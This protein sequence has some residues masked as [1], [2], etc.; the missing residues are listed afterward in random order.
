MI[1]ALAVLVIVVG[2]ILALAWGTDEVLVDTRCATCRKLACD[3]RRPSYD[4]YCE[5]DC[6]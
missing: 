2:S 3:P 4:G 1:T 5:C 6:H